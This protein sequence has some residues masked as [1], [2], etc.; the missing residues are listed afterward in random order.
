MLVLVA[1]LGGCGD[2]EDLLAGGRFKDP[3]DAE[4]LGDCPSRDDAVTLYEDLDGDGQGNS[5]VGRP[6]CPPVA[7]F[8]EVAGDCDDEDP[9]VFA[10]APELCNGIDDNCNVTIDE[11]PDTLWCE[12][13]D[14]DGFGNAG[15]GIHSC[16]QPS[17]HVADCSDCDD[18]DETANP[19]APEVPGD[20]V[21][22]DCD[23]VVE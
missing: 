8:A 4:L 1:L 7:G 5:F 15:V 16:D 9:G 23:E 12:D 10:G 11:A 21:D 22:N 17:H 19:D 20:G 18:L 2:V 14:E 13:R 3:P 6:G